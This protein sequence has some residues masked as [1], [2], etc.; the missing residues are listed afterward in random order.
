MKNVIAYWLLPDQPHRGFFTEIIR[1]LATRYDAPEFEPHVT[2]FVAPENTESPDSVL[3]ELA[4]YHISLS[5]AGIQYSEK[6]TKTLFVQ[7]NKTKAVQTLADSLQRVTKARQRYT[8]NPHLSLM[9][10]HLTKG[11]KRQL[12]ET[13]QLSFRRV[14]FPAAAAVRCPSP[15][16]TAADVRSWRVLAL[17][18]SSTR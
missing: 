12:A 5:V 8:V 16:R 18:N 11:T 14:S 7:F 13:I 10:Q 1:D 3:E 6:F 4:R 17:Q 15:T 9:Y 2:V